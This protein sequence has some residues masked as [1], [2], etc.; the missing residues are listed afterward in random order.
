MD[1]DTEK[2][3]IAEQAAEWLIRLETATPAERAEFWEWLTQSPLHVKEMIAASVVDAEVRRVMRGGS[4]DAN[5]HIERAQNIYQIGNR[6]QHDGAGEPPASEAAAAPRRHR[7]ARWFTAAAFCIVVVAAAAVLNGA[8]QRTIVTEAGEWETTRL[9]DNTIVQVG[10]RT[11]L[12]LKFSN[13]HRLV[14]VARGE[15]LF[16]VAKNPNRPFLVETPLAT[17]RAVG[18]AFAVS[19]DG[20]DEVRVTVKEGVVA[21]TRRAHSQTSNDTA[22]SAAQAVTLNAGEQVAVDALNVLAARRV[23]IDTALA[24]VSGRLVFEHETVEQAVR[25]FNRRNRL[26]IKVMDEALR[27]RAVRGK[28]EAADPEAF[29]TYLEKQGVISMLDEDSGTLLITPPPK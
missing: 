26:Q 8:S 25:E 9:S 16:H 27:K 7:W 5:T 17:A 4:I 18:T 14:H 20:D 28:F 15:A 23:N 10:P 1:T 11:K 2:L 3:L 22:N 21:V 29:A 12:L 24:W 19:L 13:D 6:P